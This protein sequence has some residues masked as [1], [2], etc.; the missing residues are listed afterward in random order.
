MRRRAEPSPPRLGP[1]EAVS[2]A[3]SCNASRR[4][5]SEF[6]LRLEIISTFLSTSSISFYNILHLYFKLFQHASTCLNDHSLT[7]WPLVICMEES[8][9]AGQSAQELPLASNCDFFA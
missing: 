1:L 3:M 7:A 6:I 8:P 2:R 4:A 5:D 9:V